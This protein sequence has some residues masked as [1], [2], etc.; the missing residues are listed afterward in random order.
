M[1]G[2]LR[3]AASFFFLLL[4][5]ILPAFSQAR[6]LVA[7]TGTPS[8]PKLSS[9]LE[10]AAMLAAQQSGL[11]ATAWARSGAAAGSAGSLTRDAEAI[12]AQFLLTIRFT[13]E[14]GSVTMAM[15]LARVGGSAPL[16]TR[17]ADFP[18]DLDLDARVTDAAHQ[19]LVD[20]GVEA[21]LRRA[22]KEA[23]PFGRP[24]PG[25]RVGRTAEPGAA[26]EQAA[27]GPAAAPAPGR[28]PQVAGKWSPVFSGQAAPLLLI[29]SGSDYFRYGA[30]ALFFGG[31][32]FPNR[33]M[34]I[35]T[36]LHV[37]AA[38]IF[39][40]PVLPQ[41]TVYTFL[42]GPEV[43]IGTSPDA[44]LGAGIRAG[45]GAAVITLQLPGASL[46]AKTVPFVDGGVSMTLRA[47][48]P[49]HV[50]VGLGFLA[51]FEGGYPIMGVAPA[52]LVGT[53]L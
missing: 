15:S 31:V 13:E 50:G 11:A 20:P 10:R 44:A 32:R 9:V 51:I 43:A 33:S 47:V 52:L 4:V 16:L 3:F 7:A 30:A 53:G 37:G 18:F 5:L 49:L 36:G 40:I 22:E 42:G 39:P 27:G 21:A 23:A 19:L 8:D 24:A 2:R 12:G 34:T 26:R 46:L 35:E 48:G 38:R 6:I 17:T 14:G 45:G 28:T 41:A 25:A 1:V 29:G